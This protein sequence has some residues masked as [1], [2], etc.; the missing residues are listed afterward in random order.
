LADVAAHP[1][2]AWLI[3]GGGLSVI[4]AL[5]HIACIVGG[6]EW[7]RFLGAAELYAAAGWVLPEV[8]GRVY[9]PSRAERRFGWRA[10]SDFASVLAALRDGASMP[11][12][13]DPDYTSPILTQ[14]RAECMN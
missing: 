4:A 12:A 9:D 10:R 7:Y 2:S 8:I 13:H 5:A 14:E 1:G 11:F 6:P 3:V